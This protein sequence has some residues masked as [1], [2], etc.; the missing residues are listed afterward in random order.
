MGKMPGSPNSC[1]WFRWGL[2]SIILGIPV[3][4]PACA[5]SGGWGINSLRGARTRHCDASLWVSRPSVSG[6]T[7][8]PEVGKELPKQ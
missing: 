5:S 7:R 2:G 6:P 4:S 8:S 3:A 1:I